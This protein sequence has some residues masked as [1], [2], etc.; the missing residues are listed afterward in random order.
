[1]LPCCRAGAGARQASSCCAAAAHRRRQHQPRR[2]CSSDPL[3]TSEPADPPQ[4]LQ[5]QGPG[6]HVARRDN[7]GRPLVSSITGTTHAE[8][9]PFDRFQHLEERPLGPGATYTMTT[10]EREGLAPADEERAQGWHYP[11][12][13][14]AD[15][16]AQSP[17][18]DPYL[19]REYGMFDGPQQAMVDI[20]ADS[21]YIGRKEPLP[22][23]LRRRAPG[24][25]QSAAALQPGGTAVMVRGQE[26]AWQLRCISDRESFEDALGEQV[27][28]TT[29]M[30]KNSADYYPVGY[31]LPPNTLALVVEHEGTAQY[32]HHVC[33]GRSDQQTQVE[34]NCYVLRADIDSF[35]HVLNYF[36]EIWDVSRK[37]ERYHHKYRGLC[38]WG[39]GMD[40]EDAEYL[41]GFFDH[42]G[43]NCAVDLE[44]LDEACEGYVPVQYCPR[45]GLPVA[46]GQPKESGLW[47]P[48][49]TGILFWQN[50]LYS[51]P[52]HFDLRPPHMRQW[53][54]FLGKQRRFP[55]NIRSH[56]LNR[57][58]VD[59]DRPLEEYNRVFGYGGDRTIRRKSWLENRDGELPTDT[60]GAATAW[61]A[62]MLHE[63][64]TQNQDSI[65]D[66]F[67]HGIIHPVFTTNPG[68]D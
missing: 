35:L 17:D 21:P 24:A 2:W 52:Q 11:E 22:P 53:W 46:A 44:R 38:I 6:G 48:G 25:E 12:V 40:P 58:Q 8:L 60:G 56:V 26:R 67:H 29:D 63:R 14:R 9:S 37:N 5:Q 39:H 36:G 65:N 13:R 62:D 61:R 41:D 59:I 30:D 50:F 1:M 55:S 54:N 43:I 34:G 3:A 20:T 32:F 42:C 28:R 49:A 16:P 47:G 23:H 4:A 33:G 51:V 45:G 27:F 68:P 10:R 57:D 18:G 31:G 7:Q 66:H 15:A 19:P 64:Y